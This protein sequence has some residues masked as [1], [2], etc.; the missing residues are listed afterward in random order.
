M[1]KTFQNP[2][3]AVKTSQ[4]LNNPIKTSNKH[5]RIKQ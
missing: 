3:L 1:K 2:K 4:Q 5:V